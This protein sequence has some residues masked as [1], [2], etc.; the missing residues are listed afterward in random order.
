MMRSIMARAGA[1][2]V[3]L[4]LGAGLVLL[5][6]AA[7][8]AVVTSVEFETEGPVSVVFGEDWFLRLAVT[9]STLVRPRS[10]VA[11]ALA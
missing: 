5:P 3:A 10:L 11:A 8:A 2:I 9:S 4:G 1:A 7:S 6:T